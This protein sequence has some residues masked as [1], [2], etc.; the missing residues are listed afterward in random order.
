MMSKPYPR[1]I[2]LP[3]EVKPWEYGE[4][5]LEPINKIIDPYVRGPKVKDEIRAMSMEDWDNLPKYERQEWH[6]GMQYGQ[7]LY[8]DEMQLRSLGYTGKVS[9]L[10]KHPTSNR[11]R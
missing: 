10:R 11:Y 7:G 9:P 6:D 5:T 3:V 1:Y 2:V 8:N 4:I